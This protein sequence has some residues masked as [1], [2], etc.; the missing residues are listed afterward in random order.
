MTDLPDV[1]LYADHLTGTYKAGH[2]TGPDGAL[3]WDEY[4]A[5]LAPFF[6]KTRREDWQAVA[7][8][9]AAQLVGEQNLTHADAHYAV[10]NIARIVHD[11]EEARRIGPPE[12][13]AGDQPTFDLEGDP[14]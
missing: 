4:L 14:S 6:E 2:G 5:E 7:A 3:T 11:F 8:W 9:L 13:P 10:M 1:R 12:E